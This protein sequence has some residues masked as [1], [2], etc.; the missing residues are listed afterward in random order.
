MCGVRRPKGQEDKESGIVKDDGCP[1]GTLKSKI[2]ELR[3]QIN[4]SERRDK[5][6]G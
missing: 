3:I 4:M 6:K 1:K 5:E 2:M